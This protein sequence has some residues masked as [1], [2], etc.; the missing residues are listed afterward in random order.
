MNC[1]EC[2]EIK[3]QR[4]YA[5]CERCSEYEPSDHEVDWDLEDDGA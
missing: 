3:E 1:R 2:E 4:P 5:Q